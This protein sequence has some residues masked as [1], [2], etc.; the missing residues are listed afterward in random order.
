M[1]LEDSDARVELMCEA[2]D[3]CS[4]GFKIQRFDS[5]S[6]M[7]AQ[8]QHWKSSACLIS[9]DY[10]LSNSRT[11]NPGTGVDAVK[12]LAGIPPFCPVIVHTSL[13][14]AGRLMASTL[15]QQG[16]TVEQVR[17]NRR[18]AVALW[19]GAVEALTGFDQETD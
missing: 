2:I 15:Q 8:A 6:A 7:R 9:L 18:E 17:L 5:V 4:A 16:W 3:S 19:L 12:L 13:A 10:D 11:P 14:E 1:I